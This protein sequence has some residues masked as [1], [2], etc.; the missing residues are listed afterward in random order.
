MTGKT[1]TTATGSGTK[2]SRFLQESL[3]SVLTMGAVL[4]LLGALVTQQFALNNRATG[5]GL[6]AG[7][8]S[9]A[10]IVASLVRFRRR[11]SLPDRLLRQLSSFGL[12]SSASVQALHP[13][14]ER[15]PASNGWN[16]LI[17]TCA[18][19]VQD[20]TIERRLARSRTDGGSERFAR[21]LR[22]LPEGLAITDQHGGITYKNNAWCQTLGKA[23]EAASSMADTIALQLDAAAF[24]NWEGVK[25]RVLE[26]TRPNKWE[27]HRGSSV[28]EGVLRLE[29]TPLD[30]RAGEQTG[31]VW[32]LRDITQSALAREAHEQFLSSATHELRTPLT[33]IRAYSES[34]IE[35][36]DIS[37]DQQK[38]FFNV[39]H[40]ESGRLGRLLNQLLDIQQLEAGSMTISVSKFDVQRMAQELSE[41]VDPLIRAK[42]LSF[43]CRIAPDVKTIQADKEK[44]ISGMVNLLGNAIKYTPAGGEV[45]LLV[46]QAE[47]HVVLAVEDTGI[48]I[49]EEELPKIFDRFYRCDD[50]R[51]SDLE[52]NGLGL[53]FTMEVARLHNG[54]LTVDS[55]L[56]SGSRFTLKLPLAIQHG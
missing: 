29:R 53:S 44:I 39:I 34:L 32:T 9:L 11:L 30:G 13:L 37:A 17:E 5:Y 8:I 31:F 42:N 25:N 27:M 1:L 40:T 56:N 55:Q 28:H 15:N 12:E 4:F 47:G 7:A 2:S 38:D 22:S 24:S 35:M 49:S 48:G 23:A 36:K 16:R 50:A 6:I 18:D 33:N 19:R 51:V 45:R 21:A 41:H 46:E 52:G 3:A 14:L 20:E 54:E 26:G 10:V 43:V